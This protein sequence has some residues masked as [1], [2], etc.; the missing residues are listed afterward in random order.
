MILQK[1]KQIALACVK[2]ECQVQEVAEV[3]KETEEIEEEWD[4]RGI[5]GLLERKEIMEL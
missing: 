5:W 2:M 1:S 4:K 3:K